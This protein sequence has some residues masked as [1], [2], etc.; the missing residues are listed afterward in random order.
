MVRKLSGKCSWLEWMK[1][2]MCNLHTGFVLSQFAS[3][4]FSPLWFLPLCY[5]IFL[6]VFFIFFFIFLWPV[7][8]NPP[9]PLFVF[10]HN[11]NKKN[12][13]LFVLFDRDIIVNLYQLHF[14]PNKWVFHLS[15]FSILPT[16][17]KQE[18][19]KSQIGR[20]HVWT[21]VT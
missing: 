1:M 2:P 4:F 7:I 18:K 13:L 16:K 11:F 20:A 15:T 19:T 17:H 8:F 3:F 12:V 10:I 14:P 9:P 21:P 6:S 5:T